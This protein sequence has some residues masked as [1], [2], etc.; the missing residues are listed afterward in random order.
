M[1]SEKLCHNDDY[2]QKID[3]DSDTE[4]MFEKA[5][6]SASQKLQIQPITKLSKLNEEDFF[7]DSDKSLEEE[8]SYSKKLNQI[9]LNKT[10]GGNV[11]KE[12]KP[13]EE[14]I[15]EYSSLNESS[16]TS[17]SLPSIDINTQENHSSN[18]NNTNVNVIDNNN[19]IDNQSK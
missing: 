7:Y 4:E 9:D 17:S 1:N 8:N 6:W 12:V 19:Q 3:E 5:T 11:D 14:S 15:S 10:S 16:S 2:Y 13:R 18:I